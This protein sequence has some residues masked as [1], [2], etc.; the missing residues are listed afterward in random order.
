MNKQY[1]IIGQNREEIYNYIHSNYNVIDYIR[2]KE[3]MCNSHFPFILDL[4]DNTLSLLESIT[5]CACAAQ[6]NKIIEFNEFKKGE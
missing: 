6:N 1:F 5:A 3:Y 4:E 2:D